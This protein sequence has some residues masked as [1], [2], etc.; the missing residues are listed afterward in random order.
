MNKERETYAQDVETWLWVTKGVRF[1]AHER[2]LTQNKWSNIAVGMMSAYIIIINLI[3]SYKIHLNEAL[4]DNAVSFI[5]TALSILILVFS[6]LENSNDFKLKA[7]KFH[8]CSRE[9]AKLY[10]QVREVKRENLDEQKLNDFLRNITN[11][12]Q[13]ILDKFDNH[14]EIDYLYF[15][16]RHPVDFVMTWYQKLT[17]RLKY[18]FNT[19]FIYHLLIFSPLSMLLI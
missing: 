4:G 11:D 1:Y 19:Y 15:K 5:T 12:Y 17:I 9:I 2:Y 7:E 14:K 13:T 18:Y 3:S 6:Q 10:R 16:S 8:D